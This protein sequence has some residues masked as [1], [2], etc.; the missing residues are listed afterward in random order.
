MYFINDATWRY[1]IRIIFYLAGENNV[2]M[3]DKLV[4]TFEFQIKNIESTPT[5]SIMTRYK[6]NILLYSELEYFFFP[7]IRYHRP[8]RKRSDYRHL[9]VCMRFV[10]L[11]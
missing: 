6:E 7:L 8:Y 10:L 2:S 11:R 3:R 4:T 9:L 1:F 5:S